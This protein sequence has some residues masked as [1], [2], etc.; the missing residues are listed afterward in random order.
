MQ[1]SYGTKSQG[2]ALPR[3]IDLWRVKAGGKQMSF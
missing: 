1:A 2:M 3:K